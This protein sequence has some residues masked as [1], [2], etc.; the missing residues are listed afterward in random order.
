MRRAILVCLF[1]CAIAVGAIMPGEQIETTAAQRS[2]S[3]QT[4]VNSTQ[5]TDN[6]RNLEALERRVELIQETQVQVLQKIS[7]LQTTVSAHD[8]ALRLLVSAVLALLAETISR[9]VFNVM[10]K[11][12]GQGNGSD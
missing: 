7:E 9:L 12:K 6:Q 2:L 8:W 1:I 4:A 5:I 10:R 11:N 3:E